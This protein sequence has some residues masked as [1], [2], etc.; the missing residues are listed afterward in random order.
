MM[1]LGLLSP[2]DVL[3]EKR[4]TAVPA[5]RLE[6]VENLGEDDAEFEYIPTRE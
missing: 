2:V 1:E 3:I 6:E 4:K 5:G